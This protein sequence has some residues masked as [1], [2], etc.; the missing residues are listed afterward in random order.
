LKP[1]EEN[2]QITLN[3]IFFDFDKAVLK[4]ESFLELAQV[5]DLMKK[6][7]AMQVELM[8]HTD[9][10]G[11]EKYNLGLSKRRATAV[12]KYLTEQS[13]DQS[14]IVVSYYGESKPIDTNATKAGRSKNRRVEFKILKP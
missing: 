6:R 2:V 14:R 12:Q 8:G 1:I 9:S 5:V 11:D 13:V 10:V 3:N 7:P 4:P